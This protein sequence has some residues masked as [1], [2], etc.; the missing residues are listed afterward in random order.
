MLARL[1]YTTDLV[2]SP[3]SFLKLEN[4]LTTTQAHPLHL[5]EKS[6][7]TRYVLDNLTP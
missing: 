5:L 3:F 7:G 1:T 4:M 6:I 2:V